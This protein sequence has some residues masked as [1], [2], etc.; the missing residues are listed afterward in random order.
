MGKEC[1]W[2]AALSFLRLN[3]VVE[4]QTEERFVNKVLS[5][6]LADRSIYVA[7]HYNPV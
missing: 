7:V 1:A 5:P 2:G 4:G 6:Y 3:F